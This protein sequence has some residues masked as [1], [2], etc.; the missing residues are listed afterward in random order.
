[1]IAE[2]TIIAFSARIASGK[3]AVS[4]CVAAELNWVRASFGEYLGSLA[5][6]RGLGTERQTLQELGAGL[7]QSDPEGFCR[8]VLED[9]GWRRGYGAVVDGIRHAEMV[10]V[11]RRVADPLPVMLVFIDAPESI[12]H[13]RLQ[14]RGVSLEENARIELHSTEH[15][16]QDLLPIRA[17]LHVD[18]AG[19][20]SAAA[21]EVI[22]FLTE[23]RRQSASD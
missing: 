17:D 21:G 14:S 6:Q 22:S 9:A 8:A 16:V 11:L 12:R 4:L 1:M 20:A 15:Q 5:R 2:P 18:G 13:K 7:I 3:S 23:W 10:D 19:D